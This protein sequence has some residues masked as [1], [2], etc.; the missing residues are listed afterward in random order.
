MWKVQ[1]FVVHLLLLGSILS[2]YFQSTVLSGL[3]PM[4]TLRDLGLEP[5]ADRLVVFVSDGLRAKSVLENNCSNVPDLRSFFE[6]GGI[7]GISRASSPTVTRPCHIAIFAGF[8]EDP[9]A[10]LTNFGWNPSHYD[11]VFNRSR[12][13]IGWMDKAVADIFTKLPNGGNPFH[14]NTFKKTAISGRLRN[15][16]KVFQE[17]KK[18]LTNEENV[19][20]LRNASAVVFFLYLVDMDFAGHAFTPT[21][22]RFRQMLNTTQEIIRETHDLF[23]SVFNDSRTAYILTSD[24]GMNDKGKYLYFSSY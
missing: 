4:P 22:S 20:P 14:F 3:N 15:D 23:E 17:V 9:A 1:A 11:T 18:F 7:V 2:I 24:H 19:Q 8:N 10:A 21:S 16:K 6:D 13:A 12:H 5:P